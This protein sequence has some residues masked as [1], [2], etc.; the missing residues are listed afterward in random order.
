[1]QIFFKQ[2]K[3][4]CKE[5]VKCWFL[6]ENLQFFIYIILSI[7]FSWKLLIHNTKKNSEITKDTQTIS[8]FWEKCFPWNI[9]PGPQSSRG[10]FPIN[11]VLWGERLILGRGGEIQSWNYVCRGHR[12]FQF[13]LTERILWAAR[14]FTGNRNFFFLSQAYR[15]YLGN[16]DPPPPPYNI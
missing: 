10:Y 12:L 7:F 15:L 9:I 8:Y 1:M 11:R 3:V 16:V 4:L 5:A 14:D 13:F 6:A 2:A